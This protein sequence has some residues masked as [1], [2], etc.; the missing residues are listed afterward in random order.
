MTPERTLLTQNV[1]FRG[2][3]PLVS[4]L[5]RGFSDNWLAWGAFHGRSRRTSRRFSPTLGRTGRRAKLG[6][7]LAHR[8]THLAGRCRTTVSFP[9]ASL[10]LHERSRKDEV[11]M[12]QTDQI[13]PALKLLGAAYPGG[14]P[15]QILFEKAVAVLLAKV[16]SVQLRDLRQGRQVCAQ[17]PEPGNPRVAFGATG[18]GTNHADDGDRDKVS[19]MLYCTGIP[20]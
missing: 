15:E 17:P 20:P 11:I 19:R 7:N 18:T 3:F 1:A 8:T 5:W 13:R 16:A 6:N 9:G 2:G 12:H 10:L 14:G 4:C